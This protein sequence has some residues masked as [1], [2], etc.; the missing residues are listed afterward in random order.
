MIVR[1]DLLRIWSVFPRHPLQVIRVHY[2]EMVVVLVNLGDGAVHVV[3]EVLGKLLPLVLL[4]LELPLLL[5]VERLAVVRVLETLARQKAV[6]PVQHTHLQN[7][8][9]IKRTGG[10]TD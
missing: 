10:E 4:A 1:A 8:S 9:S 5:P 3:V 2:G 7:V 6:V